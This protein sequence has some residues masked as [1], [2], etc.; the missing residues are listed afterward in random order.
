MKTRTQMT[1]NPIFLNQMDDLLETAGLTRSGYVENCMIEDI[2]T[3]KKLI[4]DPKILENFSNDK[5]AI[6]L[7]YFRSE[8]ETEGV[9]NE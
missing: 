9:K 7:D 1:L 4:S 3:V 6:I 5:R 8:K 2:L